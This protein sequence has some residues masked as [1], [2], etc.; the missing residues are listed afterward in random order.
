MAK[1]SKRLTLTP[2][3]A[4]LVKGIS[5]GKPKRQAAFDAGYGSTIGSAAVIA[6]NTLKKINVQEALQAEF[7][8]QGITI[9]AIVKPIA[10]GLTATRTVIIR[11]KGVTNTDISDNSAFAD[12]VP[13][14]AIRLKSSG[15][16]ANFLGIGKTPGDVTI[17]FIGQSDQQRSTYDIS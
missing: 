7:A 13:D 3:E 9:E 16:A 8:K 17:N 5:E 4:K 12:E 2:K 1:Q 14:H 10:E 11:D 6:T 15:M